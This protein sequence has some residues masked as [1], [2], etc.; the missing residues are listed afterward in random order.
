MN[1]KETINKQYGQ[2]DMG[3]KIS[4]VLKSEGKSTIKLVR[5]SLA[6]IED[7]H[8]R[9]R[10]ATIELAKEVGIREDMNVLD[11]GCGIGGPARALAAKFGCYVT[12]I[13]LCKEFC[14][15]AEILNNLT[16]L[17]ERIKIREG[18]A[19]EMPFNNESFEVI[20]IQHVLMNIE[21]KK[22]IFSQIYQILRPKGRLAIYTMCS[23]LNSPLI[24]PVHFANDPSIS[25]LI[26]PEELR[27]IIIISGFKDLS[28]V[29]ETAKVIEEYQ[30]RRS[31]PRNKIPQ[32]INFGLIVP[33]YVQ[34]GRN[35]IRNLK[36]GRIVVFKGIFEK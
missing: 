25:F 32:P 1:Y 22:S 19:L 34:M 17:S 14:Q 13:D 5:E 10:L 12:G 28:W 27:Q 4:S 35:I 31:K 15:T 18:N 21:D 33:N 20:F 24:F 7:L 23:G 9:G 3:N 26:S 11:V 8:I 29:D 2:S 30:L 36:E 6:S 16:G